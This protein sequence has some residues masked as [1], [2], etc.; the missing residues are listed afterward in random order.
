VKTAKRYLAKL[1]AWIAPGLLVLAA[2]A[3]AYIVLHPQATAPY[4]IGAGIFAIG[5]AG[6]LLW[7]AARTIAYLLSVEDEG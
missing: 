7:L 4:G 1:L 5:V 3:E 2:V 6:W